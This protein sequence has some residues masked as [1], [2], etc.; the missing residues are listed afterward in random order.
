M[1]GVISSSLLQ[2]NPWIQILGSLNPY[3]FDMYLNHQQPCGPHLFHG[4]FL[5]HNLSLS[6][7]SNKSYCWLDFFCRPRS[8]IASAGIE[9]HKYIQ[10]SRCPTKTYSLDCSLGMSLAALWT[11]GEERINAL[12]CAVFCED[13]EIG[14]PRISARRPEQKDSISI[15]PRA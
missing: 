6:Y 12:D 7:L 5:W 3:S 13:V 10:S 9:W 1:S 8:T 11:T 4:S 2:D 15:Y 14:K